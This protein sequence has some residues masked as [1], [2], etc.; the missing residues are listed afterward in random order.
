MKV[1]LPVQELVQSYA[2]WKI[3]SILK[4]RRA[5]KKTTR[6]QQR[7]NMTTAT[8]EQHVFGMVNPLF[9]W[10]DG[11]LQYSMNNGMP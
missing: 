7:R 2:L 5:L 1:I 8:D 9:L 3:E 4:G 6:P 10:Q 11:L